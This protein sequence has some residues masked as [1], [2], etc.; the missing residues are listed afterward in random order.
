MPTGFTIHDNMIELPQMP[1]STC[2]GFIPV[3]SAEVGSHLIEEE[4]GTER[5]S[6]LARSCRQS[7]AKSRR[8]WLLQCMTN[9]L[10]RSLKNTA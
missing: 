2:T 6:G 4:T 5:V 3:T 1:H 10:V 9:H 7:Q 8:C